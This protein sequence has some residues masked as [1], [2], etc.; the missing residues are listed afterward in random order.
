MSVDIEKLEILLSAN[1]LNLETLERAVGH[2]ITA[3]YPEE[4]KRFLFDLIRDARAR[5]FLKKARREGFPEAVIVGITRL[6]HAEW[7]TD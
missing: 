4:K 5:E 7:R 2:N 6:S 3:D 1:G